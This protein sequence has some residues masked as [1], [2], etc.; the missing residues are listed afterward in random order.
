MDFFLVYGDRFSVT[1]FATD[2]YENIFSSLV[3][4]KDIAFW[5]DDEVNFVGRGERASDGEI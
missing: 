4:Y 3:D 1:V 5:H 2:F